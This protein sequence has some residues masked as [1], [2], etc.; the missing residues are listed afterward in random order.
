MVVYKTGSV[1]K[2]KAIQAWWQDMAERNH[3]LPKPAA[4]TLQNFSTN[5]D[6]INIS[7]GN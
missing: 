3:K 4:F 6:D 5:K 7:R 1:R 2:F